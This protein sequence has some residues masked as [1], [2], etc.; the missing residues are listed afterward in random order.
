LSR[1]AE[2]KRRGAT[3]ICPQAKALRKGQETAKKERIRNCDVEESRI[4]P[5]GLIQPPGK[6][7]HPT[8]RKTKGGVNLLI[9]LMYRTRKQIG[10]P[11]KK[12]TGTRLSTRSGPHPGFSIEKT[13]VEVG[14]AR[15]KAH[16]S[17]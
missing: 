9:D 16:T 8:A 1:G 10:S 12:K 4:P 15:K 5:P 17:M 6:R 2:K 13:V 11:A 7:L 14:F 3:K